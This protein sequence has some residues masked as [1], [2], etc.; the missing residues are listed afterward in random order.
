[1]ATITETREVCDVCHNPRRKVKT[2]RVGY[3]GLLVKVAVCAEHAK[4]LEKL[5]DLGTPVRSAS[6]K[7]K[8]WDIGE[9]E[10][11]KKAQKRNPPSA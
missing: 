8:V 10:K 4:P 7:V 3:D 6:P 11:L 9:I 1:M 2:Y 5:L